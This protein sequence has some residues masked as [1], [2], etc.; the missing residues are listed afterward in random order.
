LQSLSSDTTRI[1]CPDCS[2]TRKKKNSKDC[3]VTVKSYGKVYYCHHCGSSGILE[4]L[5]N[6]KTSSREKNYAVDYNQPVTATSQILGEKMK[7][8]T[9][10]CYDFLKTRGISKET[11]DKVGIF[12]Q[13]KWFSRLNKKAESVAF[14]YTQNGNVI[15][16][17]YRAIENKDFTQDF[18]GTSILFNIDN[19]SDDKPI[20]I[21]EGE[22][23]ACTLIECEVD[24]SYGVCS[25]PT[26]A[27][28][29]VSDGKIHPSEDKRFS[30]IWN[31]HEK[32]SK[33]PYVVIATDN[34][35]AGKS[36]A[37]ELARRI[38]KD[39]CHIVDFEKHKDFNEVFLNEGKTKVL[40]VLQKAKPYPVTGL[41]SPAEYK[42]RLNSL[43]TRGNL[44]GEST[45]FQNVD[46]IYTVLQGQLT[47]VT[48]YPSSGKSNFVDQI[49]VNLSKSSDWKFAVCSFENQP[50]IHIA[51]LMEIYSNE[52]FF[53]DDKMSPELFDDAFKW[54][55]EHFTFLTHESSEPSTIDSILDRLKIAV[56]RTGIRGAVIDPYN[57]IVMEGEGSETEKISNMLTRVQS[58]AKSYGVHIWFVAHPSKMQRYGNELPRPDG[59]SISGSMSWWAKADV[60]LTVHRNGSDSEIICWKSRYRWIGQTGIVELSYNK[61]TGTYKEVDF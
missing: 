60:G 19:L 55:N 5:N 34:D 25:V 29:K 11:A 36:L 6:S 21:T 9:Q 31:S 39:R 24:K 41:Q 10:E 14:P 47:V 17:K 44:R 20:V 16:I 35:K 53:G 15:N 52:K 38:G 8:N 32:I 50:D 45:G 30:Y 28:M 46:Q 48:G 43:R 27:T 7:A 18:G 3:V 59:M 51:R 1:A 33:V 13:L 26:G 42:E 40:E 12:S 23:D 56:A 57:Y 49:M 4:R 2:H 58:F 61:D 22:I 54:V 37:E